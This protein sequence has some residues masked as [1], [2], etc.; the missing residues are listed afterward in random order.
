MT[1]TDPLDAGPPRQEPTASLAPPTP[2]ERLQ[3]SRLAL[4]AWVDKTYYQQNG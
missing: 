1:R 2:E 4:Q 3:A